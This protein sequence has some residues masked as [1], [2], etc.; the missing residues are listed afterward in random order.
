MRMLSRK[1]LVGIQSGGMLTYVKRTLLNFYCVSRDIS[2]DFLSVI[3]RLGQ[4][5][6]YDSI[7]LVSEHSTTLSEWS[8]NIPRLYLTGQR[9][10]QNTSWCNSCAHRRARG[11]ILWNYMR[12]I[13]YDNLLVFSEFHHM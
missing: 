13:E 7:L 11:V 6:F 9:T 1:I 5:T 8:A 12:Y 2:K 3:V 10:L 4:R